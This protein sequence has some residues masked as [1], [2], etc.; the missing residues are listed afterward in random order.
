[1]RYTLALSSLLAL[2]QASSLPV[3]RQSARVDVA[4]LPENVQYF[5]PL[6]FAII[7]GNSSRSLT[8]IWTPNGNL[9]AGFQAYHADFLKLLGGSPQ[10]RIISENF[11]GYYFAHE[12]AIWKPDTNE[13]FFCSNAGNPKG[14]SGLYKNNRIFKIALS[15]LT[16]GNETLNLIPEE[17]V[18]SPAVEM[19]N[20]GTPYKGQ[21]LLAAEGRGEIPASLTLV[22]PEAPYNSTVLVDNF[23]GRRFNSLNDVVVHN[24]SGSILFTDTLYGYLQG[25]K[26]YPGLPEQVY[27]FNPETG[28]VRAVA[29]HFGHVNG[30]A[31]SPD[32]SKVY[33][34][35]TGA[36]NGTVNTYLPATIYTY[37]IEEN[38]GQISFG[39]RKLFAYLDS[40]V[41]DGIKVDKNGNVYTG[42][43]DGVHVFN[44][45]GVLLGKIFLGEGSAN[46]AFVGD[47]KLAILSE[48]RI[49]LAEFGGDVVGTDLW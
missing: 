10:L 21:L 33:L 49:Y 17:V 23:F 19:T 47:Q 25:F 12:A 9:T 14:D 4:N 13:L 35:D 42:A 43:G 18:A 24:K 38:D 32:E 5:D 30:I 45:N 15:N 39:N 20:G 40:G 7:G 6:S 2:A 22:N 1:M 34:S 37:D 46:L 3:R 31:L 16:S 41:P 8:D 28:L 36:Q 44:S 48:T 26:P 27:S 29:E 11:S